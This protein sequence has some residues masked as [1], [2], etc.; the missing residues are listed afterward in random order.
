MRGSRLA[1]TRRPGTCGGSPTRWSAWCASRTPSPRART[2][3]RSP[4]ARP[5]AARAAVDAQRSVTVGGSVAFATAGQVASPLNLVVFQGSGFV[6]YRVP[7]TAVAGDSP[8][9]ADG[10]LA[11]S[12]IDTFGQEG[13]AAAAG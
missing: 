1:A 12:E 10:D 2:T 11:A 13:S 9:L 3:S 8:E 6:R 7:G 4:Q 5:A